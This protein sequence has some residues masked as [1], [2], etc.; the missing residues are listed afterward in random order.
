LIAC[1]RATLERELRLR[2]PRFGRSRVFHGNDW[3]MENS[4]FMEALANRWLYVCGSL[5]ADVDIANL[6][7]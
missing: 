5:D 7:V 4:E 1:F 2:E 3:L 6:L